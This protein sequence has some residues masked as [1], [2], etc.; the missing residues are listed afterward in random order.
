[1]KPIVKQKQSTV[2]DI[3]NKAQS[4]GGGS[5][6]PDIA[7]DAG[8]T[9]TLSHDG[10]SVNGSITIA[11]DGFINISYDIDYMGV[12]PGVSDVYADFGITLTRN[13]SQYY[14]LTSHIYFQGSVVSQN[15][16]NN[17]YSVLIPV[18]AGDVIHTSLSSK[19]LDQGSCVAIISNTMA[20]YLTQKYV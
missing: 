14:I 12:Y 5:S 7:Y 6:T 11:N 3:I 20:R 16:S 2:Q 10:T 4:G 8:G 1:M 13:S 15:Q 19:Q 9:I 17:N 18:K